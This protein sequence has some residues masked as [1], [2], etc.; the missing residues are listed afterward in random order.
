M[1]S[2]RSCSPSFTD[3]ESNTTAH[4]NH[5]NRRITM[6]CPTRIILQLIGEDCGYLDARYAATLPNAGRW[7]C[8]TKTSHLYD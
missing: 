6:L 3:E 1:G 5:L 2:R 4:A 7:S 8:M